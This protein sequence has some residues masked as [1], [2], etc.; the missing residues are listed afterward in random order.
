MAQFEAGLAKDGIQETIR[1]LNQADLFTD[2]NLKAILSVGAEEILKSVKSAFV[3]SGHNNTLKRRTG[4]TFRKIARSDQVAVDK[5]GTPYMYV[6]ITGKDHRGQRYATKG[7]V[8]NYG[9]RNGGK[10]PA[11]YYWSTAVKATWDR[12]NKA[13]T[14][15]AAEIINS[16]R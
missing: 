16:N 13:M 4:E 8:L 14:D 1:Q 11:D 3:Q 12:A 10:I 7:F 5:H 9:R 6:T 2:E 15:K